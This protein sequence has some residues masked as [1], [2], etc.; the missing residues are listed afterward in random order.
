MNYCPRPAIVTAALISVTLLLTACDPSVDPKYK[1]LTASCLDKMLVQRQF[2]AWGG[3][4]ATG[5][6]YNGT[7][8]ARR[9]YEATADGLH[10]AFPDI[11]MRVLEQLQEGDRVV[12]KVQFSGT[13]TG[14]FSS[15]LDSGTAVEFYGVMIERVSDGR[16]VESW[17]SIDLWAVAQQIS[18]ADRGGD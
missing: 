12:T 18:A 8:L 9:T 13:H 6:S 17:H 14:R 10:L 15:M 7:T 3:C 16:I 2:D 1:Q 4:F 5:Y 11:S